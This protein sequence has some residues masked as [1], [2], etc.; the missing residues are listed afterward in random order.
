MGSCGKTLG[1]S[2]GAPGGAPI[3]VTVVDVQASSE[4]SD[5]EIPAAIESSRRAVLSSRLAASVVELNPREG[6]LV[7]AGAVLARLEDTALRAALSAAEAS[8][9][10]ADRDLTRDQALL[11]RGAATR[12]EVEKATTA[13]E[14]TRSAVM[15]ARAYGALDRVEEAIRE[16]Q[17]AQS[18][19]NPP[20]EIDLAQT[21]GTL[22]LTLRNP[23]DTA[24]SPTRTATLKGILTGVPVGR[25]A[26]APAK[27][28][29][30]QPAVAVA[31]PPTPVPDR[32]LPPEPPP[33]V[34][35]LRG[36]IPG[37]VYIE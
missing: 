13:V 5:L 29:P 31:P 15:V 12:N 28:E 7:T 35:T 8:D 10:A 4:S 22:H 16:Y 20:A 1:A 18:L 6:D 9:Q 34:R 11:A 17:Q 24:Q 26:A 32:F 14:R 19:P 3:N 33:R 2:H 27:T 21:A 30:Q 23:L 37:R 36:G 25:P